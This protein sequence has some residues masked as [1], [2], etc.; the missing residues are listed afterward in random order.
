M[1][2]PA[3]AYAL[4]RAS[5]KIKVAFGAIGFREKLKFPQAYC[6]AAYCRGTEEWSEGAALRIYFDVDCTPYLTKKNLILH[7]FAKTMTR[8]G[9]M[10][11]GE[12]TNNLRAKRMAWYKRPGY[13]RGDVVY[14]SDDSDC[15]IFVLARIAE[16][17][18][19]AKYPDPRDYRY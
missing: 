17:E 11:L 19:K 5:R 4:S 12:A 7:F 2:A 14:S 15:G 3:D 9:M 16:A 13:F 10:Q 8:D 1:L 18:M 6:T